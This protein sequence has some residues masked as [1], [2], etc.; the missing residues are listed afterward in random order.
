MYIYTVKPAN[1]D[2]PWEEKKGSL[3]WALFGGLSTDAIS[4]WVHT[5]LSLF[6]LFKNKTPI[7][8]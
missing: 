4:V 6:Y 7:E 2:H 1:K 3:F 8:V 5:T